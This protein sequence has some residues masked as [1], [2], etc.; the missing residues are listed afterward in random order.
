MW[1]K[2]LSFYAELTRSGAE[3]NPFPDAQNHRIPLA[4]L[5]RPE[6]QARLRALW[7][8]PMS[9]DPSRQSA[10]ATH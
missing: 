1:V 4:G 2:R 7:F 10:R 9:L 3:H 6:F 5:A 8:D